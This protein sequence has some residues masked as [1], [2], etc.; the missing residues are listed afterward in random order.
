MA[1]LGKYRGKVVNNVDP[2]MQGRIIALVPTIS[3]TPLTWAT[4]CVPYAGRG[5]GFFAVP[6]IGA[7]V[8]IEFE[9]GEV[10]KPIWTGCFWGKGE[11]PAKP[12]VPTTKVLKTELIT[13]SFN[14][15]KAELKLEVKTPTGLQTVEMDP[16][17]IKLS[18]NEVTVTIS[19]KAIELKN[20]AAS[21]SVAPQAV[22]VKN[23]SA[24]AEIEP[25]SVALK[26]GGASVEITPGSIGL[27][28]GGASV[29]LSPASV[30][31][32]KGALE[33]I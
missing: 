14:D 11:A 1:N 12:A 27:K 7:N 13:L 17:G 24:V 19:Q 22:A 28:N 26:N 5:V 31:L 4:P 20:A 10:G 25:Q 2:L 6:P 32:N 16:G 30:S 8:W 15:L 29:D 33:V 23:G 21:V 9:G 18:S 3:E